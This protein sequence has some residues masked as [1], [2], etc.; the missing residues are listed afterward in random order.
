MLIILRKPITTGLAMS[1]MLPVGIE[2]VSAESNSVSA[3]SVSSITERYVNYPLSLQARNLF[4]W[5][6][7]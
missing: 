6:H 5:G 2:A 4:N 7:S 3:L 1:L